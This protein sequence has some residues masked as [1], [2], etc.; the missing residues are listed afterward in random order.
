VAFWCEVWGR[1]GCGGKSGELTVALAHTEKSSVGDW[2]REGDI[3][4]TLMR[5]MLDAQR[6]VNEIQYSK[7]RK[8]NTR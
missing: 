5:Q 7:R 6:E 4:S 3:W 8:K 2:G 1:G